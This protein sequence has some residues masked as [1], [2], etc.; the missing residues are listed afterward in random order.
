MG[1]HVAV[2]SPD[3]ERLADLASRLA[4]QNYILHLFALDDSDID[5][6]RRFEP[7]VVVVDIPKDHREPAWQLVGAIK[8]DPILRRRPLVIFTHDPHFPAAR[9]AYLSSRGVTLV[10]RASPE[11]LCDRIAQFLEE[12]GS[13]GAA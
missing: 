13:V 3:S 5:S 2:I 9:A 6:L 10:P 7:Q 1:K 8:L 11:E 4:R 12:S